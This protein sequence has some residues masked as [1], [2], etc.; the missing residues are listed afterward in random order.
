LATVICAKAVSATKEELAVNMAAESGVA[1]KTSNNFV[2]SGLL[3]EK[4]FIQSAYIANC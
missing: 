4:N 3:N 1:P 2:L